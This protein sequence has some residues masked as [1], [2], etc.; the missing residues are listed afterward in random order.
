MKK[1]IL[2]AGVAVLALA[3]VAA[4]YTFS[5]N[6]TVGST[7]ADVVALQQALIAAGQSIPSIQS[8]AAQPG[9]FGSQTK[10]AVVAF[11][12]ANGLPSTG[13]VGPLTRGVL[14]GTA[15]ASTATSAAC[16]AGFTCTPVAGVSASTSAAV[17]TVATQTGI[18]T[19]GVQGIMSVTQGPVSVSTAYAGQ[20]QVPILDARIQAQYSDLAVQS[21]QVDLGTSTNIYNYVYSK[22]YLIDPSTGKV[23]V[24][25]PL[26][27]STVVQNGTNYVVGL[28][29]FNFIVPKGTFKDIQ[30]AVDL[31]PTILNGQGNLNFL[32]QW[33]VGFDGNSIRAVD[34]AGVNNY[35]PAGAGSVGGTTPAPISQS[36][37]VQQNQTLNATANISLDGSSPQANA[38]GVTNTTAGSYLGLPVL[39]FDVNAQG[40]NLHL[41]SLAINVNTSNISGSPAPTVNAAYLYQGSTEIMSSSVANGVATFSNIPD[42]TTGAGIPVNTTVPFTVKVDVTGPSNAPFAINVTASTSNVILY[43]S[44]DNSITGA[45]IATGNIQTVEGQGA[46]FS[47][48]GTPSIT[49]NN[50]TAGGATT[51]TYQYT[52]TFNVVATAIGQ[53]ANLGLPGAA[54]AAFGSSTTDINH[55]EV[56]VD[57][58]ASTTV[59]QVIGS[60]SQPT[61]TALSANGQYF[62]LAQNQNVTIPVTYSF[63]IN[64]PGA[65]TY[66]VQLQGITWENSG[67]T[68]TT[69]SNFMVNQPLWRTTSI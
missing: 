12:T 40:D 10:A 45:G 11:Q 42:G 19:P 65:H 52:A 32:G 14:N 67:N 27:S 46:V 55:A 23:L 5:N 31:Y 62:T 50:I 25:E 6:L 7:G 41:H 57:G 48:S 35:G 29:G 13:F 66:A 43:G 60:Y 30:V 9:Y 58:S 56:Y 16:P 18:T 26:N 44:T 8:G 21:L 39:V 69:T 33:T 51:T 1:V 59:A 20:T 49:K 47:L 54:S 37:N 15:S 36:V 61:N 2:V 28:A 17:T 34:G 64:N 4:A 53:N 68:A 63:T 38:V 3:S 24:S 22:I